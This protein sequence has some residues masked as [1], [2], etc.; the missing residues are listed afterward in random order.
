M[1]DIGFINEAREMLGEEKLDETKYKEKPDL[2]IYGKK[3]VIDESVFSTAKKVSDEKDKYRE[4]AKKEMEK[5][6]SELKIDPR[7]EKMLAKDVTAKKHEK[8]TEKEFKKTISSQRAELAAKKKGTNE[9]QITTAPDAHT[10]PEPE[11]S[12]FAYR[13]DKRGDK[14]TLSD[15]MAQLQAATSEQVRGKILA[16]IKKSM[17][18]Q[19]QVEPVM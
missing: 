10:T 15:L 2:S 9:A 6:H 12:A 17:G 8:P 11:S 18:L 5:R 1:L 7:L 13:K 4:M 16:R 19:I 3:M 14:K